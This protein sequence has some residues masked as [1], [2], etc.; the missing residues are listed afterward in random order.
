MGHLSHSQ[1][2]MYTGCQMQYKFRYIE[3]IKIAPPGAMAFGIAFDNGLSG[4]YEQKI[5]TEKDLSIM[6]VTDI[7]EESFEKFKDADTDWQGQ[8]PSVLKETGNGLVK[9]HMLEK[10][11]DIMPLTV[12][13]K[14]EIKINEDYTIQTITDIVTQD[15]VIIDI[16][17]AGKSPSKNPDGTYKMS[18][19]HKAQGLIYDVA[20]KAKY[21]RDP[22][23][24]KFQYHVKN[25][26]PK[27][28]DAFH[29]STPSE[30]EFIK[31]Q[32]DRVFKAIEV[33]KENNSFYPNRG[34]LMCSAKQCGYF[35]ICHQEFGPTLPNKQAEGFKV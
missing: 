15:A 10:A 27:I 21:G 33:S 32:Y 34:Y 4:N 18:V 2:R 24:I 35:E 13:D 30:L 5:K 3:G 20:Y 14:V 25:K 28:C 12:Q 19:D 29:I 16:K 26:N 11:K 17:T 6:D 1:V 7:F 23:A 9:V 31:A 22:F 8:D